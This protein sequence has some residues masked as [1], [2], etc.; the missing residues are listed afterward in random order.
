[1]V[2]IMKPDTKPRTDQ[3]RKAIEVYCREVANALNE[4]GYDLKAVLEAKPMEVS[5]TQE[6]VKDVIFRRLAIALYPVDKKGEVLKS[7]TQLETAWV[8]KVY[9]HMNRWLAQNFEHAEHVPFPSEESMMY[10]ARQIK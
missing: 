9:D 8:D 3:Q 2:F 6:N 1:M 4:A 5:L 7:T 10:E